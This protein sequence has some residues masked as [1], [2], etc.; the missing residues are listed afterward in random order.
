MAREVVDLVAPKSS[1]F[2]REESE[3][4][5]EESSFDVELTTASEAPSSS[6]SIR[7]MPTEGSIGPISATSPSG[8]ELYAPRVSASEPSFRNVRRFSVI[9]STWALPEPTATAV[10]SC[11]AAAMAAIVPIVL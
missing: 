11:L 6:R 1:S 3:F 7:R 8:A 4:S 2:S 5:I 9:V 10:I